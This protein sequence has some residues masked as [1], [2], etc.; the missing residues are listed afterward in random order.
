MTDKTNKTLLVTGAAR[1]IGR[2]LVERALEQ[3]QHVIAVVRKEADQVSFGEHARLQTVLMDLADSASVER[4]FVRVDELLAGRRLHAIVNC[5]AISEPGAVE[6]TDM[7]TFERILNTNTLGSLRVLKQALPRLRGHGGRII[8][9][10]S[11]WGQASGPMLGAYC[12]SKHAV[13][14]LADTTRRETRGMNLHVI[15]A[16]PGVVQTDMFESQ[17]GF[18]DTYMGRMEPGLRGLYENLYRRYHKLVSGAPSITADA[19]CEGLEKAIHDVKP[20]LRYQIGN[21][22]KAIVLLNWLLPAGL[23]DR[24]LGLKLN[25]KPL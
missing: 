5:A 19:C 7:E 18:I 20:K 25:N 2:R 16:E 13:E 1:G 9:V 23:M 22:S 11:L 6:A 24:L 17:G 8:L 14:S 12:A 4:G 15:V 3:G 10:T 21:D